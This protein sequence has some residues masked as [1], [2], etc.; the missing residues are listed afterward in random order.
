[1]S[2]DVQ[3]VMNRFGDGGQFSPSKQSRSQQENPN[4]NETMLPGESGVRKNSSESW[5]VWEDTHGPREYGSPLG[6]HVPVPRGCESSAHPRKESLPCP[7]GD[8]IRPVSSNAV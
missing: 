2:H 3:N 4:S 5:P 8:D 6:P 1:M 7:P